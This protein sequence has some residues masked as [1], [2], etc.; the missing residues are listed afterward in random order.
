MTP[1][2]GR[3]NEA[4]DALAR[5]ATL[6]MAD[7]GTDMFCLNR[8]TTEPVRF[9]VFEVYRDD[10]AF[11]IHRANPAIG[12]VS[13]ELGDLL[14]EVEIVIGGHSAGDRP[15]TRSTAQ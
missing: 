6:A 10:A 13:A 1:K 7:D 5:I 9:F 3:E 4:A 15:P 2:P 11:A 14:G 12:K 8:T